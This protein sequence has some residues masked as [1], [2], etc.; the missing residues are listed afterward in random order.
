MYAY[1]TRIYTQNTFAF[2]LQLTLSDVCVR[3]R[4]CVYVS[5]VACARARV[6]ISM[7][8]MYNIL[9]NSSLYIRLSITLA[10]S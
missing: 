3:A 9:F 4:V 1:T 2:L 6:Y 10:S 5:A 8:I 7:C